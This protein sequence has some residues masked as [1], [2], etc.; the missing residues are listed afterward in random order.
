VT[1][2]SAEAFATS[3]EAYDHHVGRYGA[4]LA[5]G[6]IRAAGI[7]PGQRVL[8]VGCGPGPLTT[9]LADLLGSESVAAVDPSEPFV[10]ACRSRVPGADVRVGVGEQLPFEADEFDAVL[11]QL[12]IQLMEDADA[13]ME[14]M[15]RVARPGGTIA[16]CVWDS[17][18]MPVLRSFWDAALEVAP[19]TAGALDDAQRVGYESPEDLAD[20][21]RVNRLTDVSTGEI[22]V[23]ADYEGFDDLFRPFAAGAGHSGACFTSL[24]EVDQQ[25]LRGDV[26]R[27]LGAPDGPFTLTARAWWVRGTAP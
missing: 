1:E 14:E 17:R 9:A 13:G 16:A 8:D 23:H 3:A 22:L 6:L 12:V 7:R 11:A 20:L 19:G 18:T 27:R 26:R 24:A 5:A 4:Q 21:C 15:V 2:S 25:R 10:E